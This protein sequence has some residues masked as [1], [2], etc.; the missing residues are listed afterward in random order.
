MIGEW[1]FRYLTLEMKQPVFIPRQETEVG[2][3]FH[4]LIVKIRCRFSRFTEFDQNI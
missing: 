4:V 2:P 3:H 1:D